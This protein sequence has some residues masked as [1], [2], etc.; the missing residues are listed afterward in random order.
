M[1]LFRRVTP[2]LS[3]ITILVTFLAI[4]PASPF[5]Q[6]AVFKFRLLADPMTLDW[7]RAHTNYETP[8]MMNLMEGLFEVDSNLK[9]K[10]CLAEKLE[11][12]KDQKVYTF[13]IRKNVKWS[14]GVGLKAQD[15][16]EGWKRLL[17]PETAAPYA[18]LLYEVVGAEDFNKGKFTDFS[19]VSV[20]AKDDYTLMVTLRKPVAYFQYL[21]GFWPLFPIRK[22]LIDKHGTA[23]T[24]P[25]K[26]VT[27][28][29]YLL[30]AYQPQTKMVF[31]A[32]PKY[33]REIGN[34]TEVVGQ[35]IRDSATALNVF[36]SGGLQMMQ[37]FSP[38][39]LK[40]ARPMPEFHTF[41]YL[42]THY[43]AYRVKNSVLDNKNLRLAISHA[44]DRKP[45]PTI[46]N[47]SEKVASSFIPPKVVGYESKLTLAF[48][49]KLAKEYLDKS[50]FDTKKE[51]T[52]VA[53][54]SERPRIL[55]Q[56][57]QSELK[58]NLGLKVAI[59]LFDPKVFQSEIKTQNYPMMMM[60]W[61][62]DYP[63]GDSFMGLFE[64][65]TGNNMTF[66][67]NPKVD[68]DLRKAREDWNTLK[69]DQYYK[70]AQEILQLQ[71]AAILPLF[72]EENEALV[73]KNIKGFSISP[74]GYFFMKDI[75]M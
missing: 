21:A 22:D 23:W 53:R 35:I 57:I 47:G 13:K 72:Y 40:M 25:G 5:A 3:R 8:M 52:I 55:T 11:M 24:R 65:G 10:P 51:I 64:T 43:L 33:W 7:H 31:K 71:E 46:L 39:D 61:S 75:Q 45:L 74:V 28:G 44:I 37:D 56:Y 20:V 4:V 60:T 26:L 17:T 67:S 59:Q 30:D 66:F 34:V 1:K 38:D 58:K 49:A 69:R 62:G 15:F 42:K 16:V 41:P 19:K 36:K 73:S 18:Y 2:L 70:E 63:D 12:S 68:E 32:N 6:G 48:D 27:V 9:P 29:P 14:D 50:G 54:N